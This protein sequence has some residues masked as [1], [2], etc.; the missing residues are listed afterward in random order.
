MGIKTDTFYRLENLELLG[1]I[2]MKNDNLPATLEAKIAEKVG[3]ELIDLIEPAEWNKLVKAQI[4]SYK[5]KHIPDIIRNEMDNMVRT[6]VRAYLD[7]EFNSEWDDDLQKQVIPALETLLKKMA[8]NIVA[9]TI[10][11]IVEATLQ[12]FKYNLTGNY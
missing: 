7:R 10:M 11:P 1:D 3:N 9:A 12:N 5:Q 2:K 4:D 6:S 8:P